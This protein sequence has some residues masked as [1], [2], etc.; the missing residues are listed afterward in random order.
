LSEPANKYINKLLTINSS[1]NGLG[2][3]ENI[4]GEAAIFALYSQMT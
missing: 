1:T 4:A 2:K 3:Q